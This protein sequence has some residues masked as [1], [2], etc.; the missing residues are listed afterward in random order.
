MQLHELLSPPPESIEELRDLVF[1]WKLKN[2]RGELH[3]DQETLEGV[4]PPIYPRG[5]ETP[6][7]M[8]L[9]AI[10]KLVCIIQLE[11]LR[12]KILDFTPYLPPRHRALIREV[13]YSQSS[14]MQAIPSNTSNLDDFWYGLR[15]VVNTMLV[16]Q[17]QTSSTNVST[18]VERFVDFDDVAAVLMLIVGSPNVLEFERTLRGLL[19]LEADAARKSI[20]Q[21]MRKAVRERLVTQWQAEQKPAPSNQVRYTLVPE[22]RPDFG[23]H[24]PRAPWSPAKR[25]ARIE[26]DP[27]EK[28]A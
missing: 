1:Q 17:W 12:E 15:N 13:F 21:F 22:L 26:F 7:F 18:P 27:F 6:V 19:G 24:T 3:L 11:L 20:N 10:V 23:W 8:Y 16:E 28:I 25:R 2:L 14:D 4:L 5:P 9:N